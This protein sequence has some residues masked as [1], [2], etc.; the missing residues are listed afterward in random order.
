MIKNILDADYKYLTTCLIF[1]LISCSKNK[2]N[3]HH[4]IKKPVTDIYFGQE[5]K[6]NYRWLEDDLSSELKNG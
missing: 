3:Y 6:D 5:V 4:T 2:I 1:I